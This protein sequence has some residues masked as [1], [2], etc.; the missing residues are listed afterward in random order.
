MK[1]IMKHIIIQQMIHQMTD[2]RKCNNH[3]HYLILQIIMVNGNNGYNRVANN[4]LSINNMQGVPEDDMLDSQG[5]VHV[6]KYYNK[7]RNHNLSVASKMSNLS[8]MPPSSMSG[9]GGNGM[10]NTLGINQGQHKMSV[11]STTSDNSRMLWDDFS[12]RG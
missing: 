7:T 9:M 11:A 6:N 12:E 10:S 5:N 2:V 3:Q 4:T 8:E 1:Q